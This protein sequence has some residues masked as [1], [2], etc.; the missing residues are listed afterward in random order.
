MTNSISGACRRPALLMAALCAALLPIGAYAAQNESSRSA[1]DAQSATSPERA[2]ELIVKD[3]LSE[4]KRLREQDQTS[5]KPWWVLDAPWIAF[6]VVGIVLVWFWSERKKQ[7][8]NQE[9]KKREL[10]LELKKCEREWNWDEDPKLKPLAD[11]LTKLQDQVT[12]L[13]SETEKIT[14]N[15]KEITENVAAA[16]LF[17]TLATSN[18][19]SGGH[20]DTKSGPRP[21]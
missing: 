10:E 12:A 5:K 11:R 17:K 4:Y 21:E 2:D 19:L 8:L 18:L 13:V 1:P 6:G 9:V 20:G 15:V 16:T 14:K 3:A 7:E